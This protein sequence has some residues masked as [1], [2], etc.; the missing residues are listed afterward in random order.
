MRLYIFL[1]SIILVSGSIKIFGL[2]LLDEFV[3][4]VLLILLINFKYS[5]KTS[6]DE[7]N[8]KNKYFSKAIFSHRILFIYLIISLFYGLQ[9]ELY[10]GKIRWLLI[11]LSIIYFEY[12]LLFY[13]HSKLSLTNI[14][15]YF[16]KV[17]KFLYFFSFGYLL[18]GLI[19]EK[20][21]NIPI[22]NIQAAEVQAWYAIWGTTAYTAII[23]L[24]LLLFNRIAYSN[25]LISSTWFFSTYL[26]CSAVMIFFD[27]RTLGV[28]LF[29]FLL[30]EFYNMKFSH[31]AASTLI[32]APIMTVFFLTYQDFFNQL[33]NSGGFFFYLIDENNAQ[34]SFQDFDRI[35]H[36]IA[37]YDVLSTS[38][39]NALLGGGFLN[40]GMLIKESYENVYLQFGMI[41]GV[42][43]INIAG[44]NQIATFGLSAYL[45]ENGLIG[46]ILLI[47]HIYNLTLLILKTNTSVSRNYLI[48]IYPLLV[49][50]LFTIY[51]NDNMLYYLLL[52][53]TA[54]LCPLILQNQQKN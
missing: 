33:L 39:S 7:V 30:A 40:A 54:M 50:L 12:F 3:F 27:T 16:S 14:N 21:F 43:N 32:I 25:K 49:F 34:E 29:I 8:L 5:N 13:F 31:K 6:N 45:I 9:T 20:I 37:A 23:F 53:P 19:A 15:F 10:F 28:I 17:F 4:I 42:G 24:P 51:I 11:L 47:Y 26:L 44:S 48:A 35:A 46:L 36:Y 41:P 2:S 52:S 1:F 38:I 22:G 18:Y